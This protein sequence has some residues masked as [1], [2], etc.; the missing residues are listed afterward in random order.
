LVG[1]VLKMINERT[2]NHGAVGSLYPGP[3]VFVVVDTPRN[4]E[5]DATVH[6]QSCRG[7]LDGSESLASDGKNRARDVGYRAHAY[8]GG[9]SGRLK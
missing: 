8:E 1:G 7:G 4:N 5:G 9:S 3:A 6:N 2:T